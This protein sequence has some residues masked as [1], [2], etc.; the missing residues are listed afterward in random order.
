VLSGL[1]PKMTVV[2]GRQFGYRPIMGLF[3]RKKG[4]DGGSDTPGTQPDLAD[5]EAL[6]TQAENIAD[7]L[8]SGKMSLKNIGELT[9]VA[10]QMQKQGL[11]QQAAVKTAMD[12]GG[13]V[14]ALMSALGMN[15]NSDYAKRTKC[16]SC[17]APKKLPSPTAYLYCDYCGALADYDFRLATHGAA[18]NMPGPAYRDLVQKLQGELQ[19]AKAA[20]DKDRY[21]AAQRQIYDGYIDACPGAVSHRVGDPEYRSQY[22]AYMAEVAATTDFDDEYNQLMAEMTQ[23]VTSLQWTGGMQ[24]RKVGSSSFRN[25]VDVCGRQATRGNDLTSAAGLIDIDPDHTSR[26]VREQ[27]RNSLFCQGWLPFLTED[28]AAWFISELKLDGTY[29]KLEIPTDG[30]TRH[31]AGCGG[32]LTAL[33]GAKVM[34]CDHCGRSVDVGGAQVT[35][36]GCGGTMSFPVG[37]ST[38]Q[39]PYCQAQ[40]ERIGWT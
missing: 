37:V 9:R 15:W 27:M 14:S 21:K 7:T 38:I 29:E 25:L 35:C 17:G 40:A 3:N 30:E 11:A 39:C 13:G 12:S 22:T 20:G 34:I 33:P 26:V 23:A 28:Y 1:V 5:M 18:S 31:C 19:A 10:R 32:D 8:R 16:A 24:D 4:G 36:G 2:R 6:S